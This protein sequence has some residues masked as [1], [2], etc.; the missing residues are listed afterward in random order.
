MTLAAGSATSID[1]APTR[2]LGLWVCLAAG[3]TTLVDQSVIN[4]AVPSMARDLGGSTAQVQWVLASYSLTFGLAL[5]PAGRFGDLRGRRPLFLGGIAL[6][7]IGSLVSGL[8]PAAGFVI[9][10]RLLQGVGAGVISSQVLGLVQD[11]FDGADRVK[12]LA[13]Y[14]VAG[15]LSGLVGPVIGAT[16]I[17][18]LPG[19]IGWRAVVA[20]SAPLALGTMV[21]GLR[22][23]PRTEPCDPGARVRLDLL[24]LSLLA[25]ATMALLL[26]FVQ[27]GLPTPLAAGLVAA[28]LAAL[29]AFVSWER[30]AGARVPG[31]VIVPPA[32]AAAPGFV[33]GTLVSTF[34]FGAGQAQNVVVTLFLLE[35]RHV[36][37][38]LV[39]AAFLPNAAAFAWSSAR[40]WRLTARF[41]TRLIAVAIGVQAL[42]CLALALA[43]PHLGA[44]AAVVTLC[45]TNAVS[46]LAGGCVDA[47]N[48]ATTLLHTPDA[49]RGV[50]AGFL[51]LAQR[52]S[53]TVC[54]AAATGIALTAG[55]VPAPGRVG[56]ALGLGVGLQLLS[57]VFA[58]RRG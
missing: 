51:Q 4:L 57:L 30:Y 46:G 34:W 2:P 56:A 29:I 32:L 48:R 37:P 11:L 53:A 6:F 33:S 17:T 26:P 20:L 36:T 24:G 35:D 15:G 50:A 31:A 10:A 41:G 18:V 45:A 22:W 52:L 47:P 38:L 49:S 27:P 42:V 14:G 19:A 9:L 21:L 25:V 16:L 58:V 12:A 40:S 23:L 28:A 8:A 43:L 44:A 13:A 54:I 5:V 3:F 39:A 55:G 1:A 7:G